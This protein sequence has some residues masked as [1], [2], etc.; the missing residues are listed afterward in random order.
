MPKDSERFFGEAK[1]DES[2]RPARIIFV[3]HGEP[4]QYAV[5]EAGL[6]EAGKEQVRGYARGYLE[7]LR[8]DLAT[9]G[10]IAVKILYS[11]VRRTMES[12]NVFAEELQKLVEAEE[13]VG[14]RILTPRPRS[15]LKST[16]TLGPLIDAGVPKED[17][18]QTWLSAEERDLADTGSRTPEEIFKVV[19][20][21]A[22]RKD[23]LSRRV[24][25]EGER[26]DYVCWTHET[27]H[28][29][30]LRGLG[31]EALRPNFA[32]PIEIDIDSS[33]KQK[34]VFRGEE[35]PVSQ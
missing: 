21:F 33:G 4:E 27:T 28:G 10:R 17:A 19:E 26:L 25:E 30:L 35:I 18:Y 32:E 16:G 31:R 5:K 12:A 24:G 13:V 2:R 6:S 9:G 14:V 1:E 8:E 3:R 7:G 15:E 22:E 23:A 20:E 29:G 34:L 11:D